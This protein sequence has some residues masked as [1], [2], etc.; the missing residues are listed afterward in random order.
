[1]TDARVD[2]GERTN[3][4]TILAGRQRG[5]AANPAKCRAG[6]C[7]TGSCRLGVPRVWIGRIRIE[8]VGDAVEQ[9]NQSALQCVV[10]TEVSRNERLLPRMEYDTPAHKIGTGGDCLS[11]ALDPIR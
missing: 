10:G 4:S 7:Q 8:P 3:E 1:M 9:A 2:T 6:D 5:D 11:V